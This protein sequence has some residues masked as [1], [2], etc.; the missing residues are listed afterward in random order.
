RNG[1]GRFGTGGAGRGPGGGPGA[2][3]A[4]QETRLRTGVTALA[5]A[6][7]LAALWLPPPWGFLAF[8]G[9]AIGVW[10]TTGILIQAVRRDEAAHC[11]L[12][13]DL[14]QS[15]KLSAL[16][17]ISSGIAHEINNPLAVIG[18][19]VELM[20]LTLGAEPLAGLPQAAELASGVDSVETQVRRCSEIT[21][22]ILDFARKHEPLPQPT[23]INRLVADMAHWVEREARSRGVTV[24]L[25]PAENLGLVPADSPLLRQVTLNVVNNAAQAA[26]PGG[27]VEISTHAD[28]GGGVRI[29]VRD[30]GPGIRPRDLPRL[31]DPFFTTK[32][33]GQGTGLGLSISQAIMHRMG[34]GIT[35]ESRPGEMTCFT[36][37][38]PG[39]PSDRGPEG[40]D[41]EDDH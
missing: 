7:L 27:R 6:A 2:E 3:A 21:H 39:R 16:G 32:P 34:G 28:P 13:E 36:I 11:L 33:P 10:K 1:S 29:E 37:R 24:E 12:D 18:Q 41:A 9:G 35:A 8:V 17:E 31:F 19:E 22:A 26:G 40:Y 4:R 30:S 15:Q 5:G 14:I 38:V 20:R 23:D 25:R